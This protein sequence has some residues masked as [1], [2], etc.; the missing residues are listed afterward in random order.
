MFAK[1]LLDVV[2]PIIVL[3]AAG[4][5]LRHK[6]KLDVQTLAKLN[7]YFLV[8]R[9]SFTTSPTASCRGRTWAAS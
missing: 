8:P 7:I 6:F 1:I 5:L 2:G 3:I 4:A 9:S